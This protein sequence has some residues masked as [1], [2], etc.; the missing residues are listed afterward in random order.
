MELFPYQREGVEWLLTHRRGIFADE[1]GMGKTVQ[2]SV[3]LSFIFKE[4]WDDVG[5]LPRTLIICPLGLR[6]SWRSHIERWVT[7]PRSDEVR[8]PFYPLA[9]V[10]DMPKPQERL[11]LLDRVHVRELVAIIN[12]DALIRL[13]SLDVPPWLY[14]WDILIIDESH[15]LKER[16]T[17]TF[18]TIKRFC[19]APK[20]MVGRVPTVRD[21]RVLNARV[22]SEVQRK[23]YDEKHTPE[24]V[25]LLSGTPIV[26]TTADI[27]AQL[28]IVDRKRWRG[29]WS[30]VDN[31]CEKTYNGFGWKVTSIANPN[32]QRV[33]ALARDI[34]PYLLQRSKED[35]A[36]Q[37]PPKIMVQQWL[38]MER[39]PVIR[40]YVQMEKDF[41]ATL[42]SLGTSKTVLAPVVLAQITRLKQIAIDPT[43]IL[44]RDDP[45]NVPTNPLDETCPKVSGLIE[46]LWDAIPSPT[47]PV[48]I[49]SQFSHVLRRLAENLCET[50]RW[51][52]AV[53]LFLGST[54]AKERDEIVRSF[55]EG[56]GPAILLISTAAGGL[57][58]TLTQS[59]RVA[60]LD[61]LWS[62]ALNQQAQ[63]RLHR[64]GQGH[65]VYI[66]EFLLQKSIEERIERVLSAKVDSYTSLYQL[67]HDAYPDAEIGED[68]PI[69]E[70]TA[71][72]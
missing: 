8:R 30:F 70:E 16:G 18:Q 49:F 29:Y 20:D 26:N 3:A 42:E 45:A 17:K 71:E 1:A 53:R 54:P 36:I 39:T 47:A 15:R 32:D 72:E 28:H 57:G 25:W 31:Y 46:W 66:T 68:L 65:T 62:P 67:L 2:A 58:L 61:K 52:G 40:P 14:Q 24:A 56:K 50:G 11:Q 60:F 63:D 23:R 13:S 6:E 41:L 7:D 33:S 22:R 12:Y 38:P 51:P 64:I 21:R 35:V 10:I 4:W 9:T 55:Q 69:E 43:L 34:Q 59:C 37:L 5:R 27:W 48:V 19:P 44:P